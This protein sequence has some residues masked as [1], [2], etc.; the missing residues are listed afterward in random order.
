MLT[1]IAIGIF[2]VIFILFILPVL[3]MVVIM[4]GSRFYTPPRPNR[5]ASKIIPSGG[6]PIQTT[7][8]IAPPVAT[9]TIDVPNSQVAPTTTVVNVP[10]PV[11]GY[12]PQE[13]KK[14][15]PGCYK[16]TS[17]RALPIMVP[18]LTI[19]QCGKLARSN[20]SV[21]FGMQYPEGSP[22]NTA[23]CFY[24]PGIYDRYGTSTACNMKDSTGMHL[25]GV[26]ANYVY[27]I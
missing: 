3:V 4:V 26:W 7:I 19:E 13:Y 9:N 27:R 5:G 21:Y 16:D 12:V 1:N 2:I 10:A 6:T 20:G 11:P 15:H 24:G 8:D 22:K 23:Q 18:N 25:G 17:T 14:Y